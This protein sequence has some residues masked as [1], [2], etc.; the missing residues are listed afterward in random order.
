[1]TAPSVSFTTIALTAVD[2]DSPITETLMTALR[3]NDIHNYEWIGYG[4]TPAQ[5]H[6]HDGVDSRLLP[7]N[8]FGNIFAY[9]N[10]R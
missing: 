5:A 6:S 2:V 9:Q 8:I 1:M 3:N 7:G 4:Y 10:Y